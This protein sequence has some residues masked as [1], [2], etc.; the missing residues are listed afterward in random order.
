MQLKS[1]FIHPE[2]DFDR[3]EEEEGVAEA[4]GDDIAPHVSDEEIELAAAIASEKE[5][6]HRGADEDLTVNRV[7][8]I[9]PQGTDEI[10]SEGFSEDILSHLAEAK[11]SEQAKV[12]EIDGPTDISESADTDIDNGGGAAFENETICDLNKQLEETQSDLRTAT[13][14]FQL[15]KSE[16]SEKK[17]IDRN[18]GWKA[19]LEKEANMVKKKM[20]K[21]AASGMIEEEA[22]EEEE[23]VAAAGLED[24]GFGAVQKKRAGDSDDEAALD[25]ILDDDLDG[26]VDELSDNE[27]DEQAGEEGRKKMHAREE[28]ERHKEILRRMRDGYDGRRG[29]IASGNARGVHRFD[30][31]ISADHKDEARRLGLLNDDESESDAEQQKSDDE[32]EDE[33]LLI[34]KMLKDRFMNKADVGILF[35]GDESEDEDETSQLDTQP[36]DAIAQEEAEQARLAKRFAKR[37]RMNRFLEVYGDSQQESESQILDEDESLKNELKSIMVCA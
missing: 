2:I 35:S 23:E 28:K 4:V 3:D 36:V 22:S 5:S 19:L 24:F 33:A 12:T 29:G 7:Q 11:K 31:L 37:A 9:L 25:Q 17:R 27:G 21:R 1:P 8:E 16:L 10:H 13:Q 20:S 34:D 32:E 26:I 30:Q 14:D 6:N 18:A 15:E